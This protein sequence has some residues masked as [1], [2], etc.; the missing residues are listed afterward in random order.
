M[1]MPRHIRSAT[2]AAIA[3]ILAFGALAGGALAAP[4]PQ[5]PDRPLTLVNYNIHHGSGD[6]DCVTPRPA[7]GDPPF[8]DCSL[9]LERI[10]AVIRAQ[11]PDVVTLQ[12]VDRFWARSAYVD[13]P[14]ALAKLL[15]LQHACYGA[16]LDLAPEPKATTRRQ[17][18]TLILSRYPIGECRNTL[19]PKFL[20]GSEQRGALEALI[21]VRGVPVRVIN[22]HL[23][24]DRSGA[25]YAAERAAQVERI[26][27]I[28]RQADE[29]VI[30]AGDLNAR[31]DWPELAPLYDEGYIDAWVAG[32]E[33][34]GYTISP[35]NPFARIDFIFVSPNIAVREA[36]VPID[37]TIRVA[38][39]HLPVVAALALPGSEVGIGRK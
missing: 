10:A 7:P 36:T 24:N 14:A 31:P 39:D 25:N 13:Q 35:Q 17:Y 5:A 29:P 2:L 30:I 38:S 19:L 26:L 16:N 1:S 12:E 33:G 27:E 4:G 11:D 8:A 23:Q 28:A 15:G 34:P 32:G 37:D 22:T 18:G 21:K 20:A 6:D 9:N 3:A